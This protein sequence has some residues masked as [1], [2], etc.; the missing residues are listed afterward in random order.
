[1]EIVNKRLMVLAG[2]L[3]MAACI[4]QPNL[5]QDR[6]QD[7]EAVKTAA[8]PHFEC[9]P[10]EYKF[11]TPPRLPPA[12]P[13]AYPRYEPTHFEA[14]K[15]L[16]IPMNKELIVPKLQ[17][18]GFIENSN[19]EIF[20]RNFGKKN[21]YSAANYLANLFSVTIVLKDFAN[22]ECPY[23]VNIY[24]VNNKVDGVDAV[25]GNDGLILKD[26]T[27]PDLIISTIDH[28]N[29]PDN[30]FKNLLDKHIQNIEAFKQKQPLNE[31]LIS[32]R[33]V[34]DGITYEIN[35]FKG[36]RSTNLQIYRYKDKSNKK[37]H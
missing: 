17:E 15:R 29:K 37:S 36:G 13:A 32:T 27:I 20:K 31:E 21:M 34:Y 35:S 12:D 16:S 10:S 14:V 11:N 23:S 22:L 18:L 25:I 4:N 6:M 19:N 7:A 30:L 26:T 33:A 1:M 3:I 9:H 24:H 5:T 28:K 2:L 8:T